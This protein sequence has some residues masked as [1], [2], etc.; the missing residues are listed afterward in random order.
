MSAMRA[1][2]GC[3]QL[4]ETSTYLVAE[5]GFGTAT[6][7]TELY[8]ALAVACIQKQVRRVL[9][10]AGDDDPAGERALR[11]ALTVMLRAGIQPDFKLALVATSERVAATYRNA[12]RDLCAAGSTTRLF[13]NE[14]NAT[15]WLESADVST[16]GAIAGP[17]PR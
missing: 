16:Q 12:Q 15:R 7:I 3:G 8:R 10:V 11:H 17:S 4:R 1:W 5:F 2:A 13:D 9:I 14:G 6:E